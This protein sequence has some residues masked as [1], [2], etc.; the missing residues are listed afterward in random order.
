MKAYAKSIIGGLIAGLTA[1][2]VSLD[3]GNNSLSTRDYVSA[4][5]AFL[6]GLGGVYYT[7]NAVKK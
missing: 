4:A 1:I 7:P 3:A 2:S 5:I 6:V